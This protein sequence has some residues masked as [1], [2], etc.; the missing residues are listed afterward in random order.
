MLEALFGCYSGDSE[1]LLGCYWRY[2]ENTMRIHWVRHW[3]MHL[4]IYQEMHWTNALGVEL[5][6]EL[7]NAL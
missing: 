7:E 2:S 6:N 5:R 4:G 3:K 1:V